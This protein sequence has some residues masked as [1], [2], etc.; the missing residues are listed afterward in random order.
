MDGCFIRSFH[1]DFGD[2]V[3]FIN[4]VVHLDSVISCRMYWHLCMPNQKWRA[5]KS[6]W[7]LH[8]NLKKEMYNI[9]GILLQ[10]EVYG[11]SV[12]DDYVWLPF[13]TSRYVAT[14]GDTDILE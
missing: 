5:N 11:H 8:D 3:D 2:E 1:A 12:S 7:L 13:V 9:G 10:D 6:Y 14:T 4:R